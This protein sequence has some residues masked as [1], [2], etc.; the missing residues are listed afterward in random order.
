MEAPLEQPVS[1]QP[2]DETSE[3]FENMDETAESEVAA[4]EL[5]TQTFVENDMNEAMGN[6]YQMI[7]NQRIYC[8]TAYLRAL[9]GSS[10]Q[11]KKAYEQLA[12]A[13]NDPA[14]RCSYNSQ[15]IFSLYSESQQLQDSQSVS[16]KISD[17]GSWHEKFLYESYGIRI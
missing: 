14:I 16:G 3:Q 15:K 1:E 7:A 9:S 10:M 13:V 11:A 12:Y 8:A 6:T 5:P 17:A 4:T 2:V